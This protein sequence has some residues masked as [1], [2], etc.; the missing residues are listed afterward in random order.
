LADWAGGATTARL[1]LPSSSSSFLHLP[2]FLLLL[3]LTGRRDL[4]RLLLGGDG[5]G[6]Q[7]ATARS[8]GDASFRRNR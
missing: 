7:V 5:E 8:C 6:L 2:S 4:M 3:S 1:L